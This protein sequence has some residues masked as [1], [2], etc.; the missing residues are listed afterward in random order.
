MQDAL[1][2]ELLLFTSECSHMLLICLLTNGLLR[3]KTVKCH[4]YLSDQ[5][6]Q[7]VLENFLL[8]YKKSLKNYL[9]VEH[10]IPH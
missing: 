1:H 2:I 7:L 10:V 4:T 8:H 5:N 6:L 3:I 9:L